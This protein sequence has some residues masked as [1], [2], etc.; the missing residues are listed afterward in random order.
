MTQ[1]QC[2]THGM[3]VKVHS[4]SDI[5]QESTE[6]FHTNYSNW[7]WR[8][9]CQV[10]TR[11]SDAYQQHIW[12]DQEGH[13]Y[14]VAKGY[15]YIRDKGQEVNWANLVWNRW[16]IPKHSLISWI[17]QHNSLNT[18]GKLYR[19]GISEVDTCYICEA[20]DETEDHLFFACDYSV[21]VLKELGDWLRI[22]LPKTDILHW[23]LTRGSS[24]IRRDLLNATINACIYHV[25]HQRNLCKFEHKILRSEQLGKLIINE[26]RIKI[27]EQPQRDWACPFL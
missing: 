2:S 15:E 5:I 23:R 6:I 1:M 19:L 17:Y 4:T 18:N 7:Y 9:I 20:A 8:K 3:K 22:S 24:L 25:W 27:L 10:K 26:I 21:K 11:F 16:S 12:T 14:S 13:N